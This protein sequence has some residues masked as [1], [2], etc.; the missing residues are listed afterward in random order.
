[1]RIRTQVRFL[2]NAVENVTYR[3]GH[4]LADGSGDCIAYLSTQAI[5]G[6]AEASDW[7]N[8]GPAR[9]DKERRN[10]RHAFSS[11][12][13]ARKSLARVNGRSA[14]CATKPWRPERHG[15]GA[16]GAANPPADETFETGR[17]SK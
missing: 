9:R 7:S 4:R 12:W 1:M 2:K 11:F 5:K 10:R 15:P 13:I 16:C 8:Q 14:T 3:L 17:R 6:M